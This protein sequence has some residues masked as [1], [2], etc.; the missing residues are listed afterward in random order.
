MQTAIEWQPCCK[1]SLTPLKGRCMKLVSP[2]PV[3]TKKGPNLSAGACSRRKEPFENEGVICKVLGRQLLCACHHCEWINLNACNASHD[4]S[5]GAGET[6]DRSSRASC[7]A[8][9]SRPFSFS[10][11]I[12]TLFFALWSSM[13]PFIES[14]R[15][16]RPTSDAHRTCE[17]SRWREGYPESP[18]IHRPTGRDSSGQK[19]KARG[20]LSS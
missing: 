13:A 20:K 19:L 12:G 4:Q 7:L 14:P 3:G 2:V 18:R 15:P 5:G 8:M 17:S 9:A 10:G 16:T 11:Q 6:L 1:V